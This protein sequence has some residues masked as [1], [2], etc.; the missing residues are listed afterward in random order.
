MSDLWTDAY[1]Y[2]KCWEV[3]KNLMRLAHHKGY[4]S[5]NELKNVQS[6]MY[7]REE[8]LKL[9]KE[10]KHDIASLT[11]L[12]RVKSGCNKVHLG[13][14]SSDVVDSA[15]VEIFKES[16]KLLSKHGRT[17]LDVINDSSKKHK[18]CIVN[19]R[20]HGKIAEPI[21]WGWR[22][23]GYYTNI[24]RSLEHLDWL[25]M[26]LCPKLS[27][28]TGSYSFWTPEDERKWTFRPNNTI[29]TQIISRD[30][31]SR[32][33]NEISILVTTYEKI[34][35]D[36]RLYAFLGQY[37]EQFSDKQRGSSSMPHKMNP[38]TLEQISGLAR[39]VRFNSFNDTES[40][41]TWLERDIA[42]SSN[43]R[44]SW[45]ETWNLS[46]Y[47]TDKMTDII[48]NL[49]FVSEEIP[50]EAWSSRNL[51]S[52]KVEGKDDYKNIQSGNHGKMVYDKKFIIDHFNKL[53]MDE[54]P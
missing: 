42:H 4:I 37:N 47:L 32:I 5:D 23:M 36:L 8:H 19:G 28:P 50:P 52:A 49:S 29:T 11:E 44:L 33:T 10:F 2:I 21:T 12:L 48:T 51:N 14:T 35:N 15:L 18:D 39:K 34:A 41:L 1:R 13:V 17:L 3:S 26:Q 46:L 45:S 9:E 30:V 16:H 6:S 38:I 7:N 54:S 22:L 25:T 43:E 40:I 31:F 20:T 24:R 27:G 53:I